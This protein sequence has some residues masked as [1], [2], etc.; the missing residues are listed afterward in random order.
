MGLIPLPTYADFYAT[1]QWEPESHLGPAGYSFAYF[2]PGAK[3]PD[4]SYAPEECPNLQALVQNTLS[5]VLWDRID[6]Q[7]MR[8]L[9]AA[10]GPRAV[11]ALQL[12][13]RAV[14]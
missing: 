9:A 10:G 6:P 14:T 2:E 8:D 5:E 13:A 4:V 11:M 7:T 3:E 1:V 12:I